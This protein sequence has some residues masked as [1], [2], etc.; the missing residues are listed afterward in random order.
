MSFKK[1]IKKHYEDKNLSSEQLHMLRTQMTSKRTSKT[2]RILIGGMSF[3]CLF[4]ISLILFKFNSLD[5]NQSLA[6]EV[7]YN[8]NKNLESEILS[9]KVDMIQEKLAKLD[10]KLSKLESLGLSAYKLVGARYCSIQ[11]KL[12]AQL[13]LKHKDT[14]KRA[15][16][17]QAY[18]PKLE[19][20]DT[21]YQIEKASVRSWKQ[22]GM[23]FSIA[24]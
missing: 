11:G 3:A 6:N 16:L 23:V 17:Y 15:T 7:V 18:H 21:E 24:R 19:I 9:D 4:L 2:T 10:F 20:G 22:D 13:K 8:H 12:A 14:G 5:L 1:D